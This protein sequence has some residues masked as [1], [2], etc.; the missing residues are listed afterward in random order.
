MR[1]ADQVGAS[2]INW[3]ELP[4]D[5]EDNQDDRN[6]DLNDDQKHDDD[7]HSL[8]D[9]ILKTRRKRRK[10]QPGQVELLSTLTFLQIPI[11]LA[12]R[13][14]HNVFVA[15]KLYYDEKKDVH[16]GRTQNNNINRRPKAKIRTWT[17]AGGSLWTSEDRWDLRAESQSPST[18]LLHGPHPGCDR[19]DHRCDD[20][21]LVKKEEDDRGHHLEVALQVDLLQLFLAL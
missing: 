21:V 10:E 17:P 16:N 15:A 3:I 11:A 18:N 20:G 19:D 13:P 8:E 5:D 12:S 2:E 7:Q 4:G 14:E 6:I 9:G 1:D